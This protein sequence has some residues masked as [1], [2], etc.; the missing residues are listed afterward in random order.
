MDPACRFPYEANN[1]ASF[2]ELDVR[3]LAAEDIAGMFEPDTLRLLAGC[4]PC[5]PFSTYSRKGRITRDDQKWELV[6]DFCRIVRDLQ[7]ELVTMENVPQLLDHPVFEQ[8]KLALVNYNV[9]CGSVE[10]SKYG[11]PQTR[12][13][14]VLLASRLGPISLVPVTHKGAKIRTVRNAIAELPPLSAGGADP[15]DPLHYASSLSKKNLKR[16]RASLPG[17]TWRDWPAYLRAECHTKMTGETYPSVYG[18]M[19]WDIPAPTITTQCFGYG[20]GRFGHPRQDRAISLR[21]AAI[22]QTFPRSYKFVS[23]G[24]RVR[25]STLGRLIGNAVPVRLGE[26]VGRSLVQHVRR[27]AG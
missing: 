13:R 18:R 1:R 24:E 5:Q 17:G 20:N 4:A 10:C 2:L 7:P 14:F 12:K 9:W 8:L 15:G 26:I 19:S 22:L 16:I 6:I 3:R 27:I 25:F 11:V 23:T 21:E